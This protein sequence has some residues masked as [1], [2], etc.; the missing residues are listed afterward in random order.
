MIKQ[1]K[2]THVH[3]ALSQLQHDLITILAG[4]SFRYSCYFCCCCCC[5]SDEK[6]VLYVYVPSLCHLQSKMNSKG[7]SIS[8]HV[9]DRKF[10]RLTKCFMTHNLFVQSSLSLSVFLLLHNPARGPWQVLLWEPELFTFFIYWQ[11]SY[12]YLLTKE[13]EKGY[14]PGHPTWKFPIVIGFN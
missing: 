2:R 10:I 8:Q 7:A 12:L 1:R 14:H 3:V 4:N 13:L 11:Q 5:W 6:P 9:S